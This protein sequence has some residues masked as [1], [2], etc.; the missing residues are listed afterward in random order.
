LIFFV[1]ISIPYSALH[2]VVAGDAGAGCEAVI[3]DARNG[4]TPHWTGLNLALAA[5]QHIKGWASQHMVGIPE[6]M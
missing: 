2:R 3:L 5:P 6:N 4:E 1:L